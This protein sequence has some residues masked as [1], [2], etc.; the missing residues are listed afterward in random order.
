MILRNS[1]TLLTLILPTRISE[2]EH[3]TRYYM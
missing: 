3:P 2:K 1:S